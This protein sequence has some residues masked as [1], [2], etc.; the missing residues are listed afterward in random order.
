[1]ADIAKLMAIIMILL[2]GVRRLNLG[3]LLF[4]GGTLLGLLER[5]PLKKMLLALG[6]GALGVNTL[7]LLAI[8]T[9]I[10]VL[11]YLMRKHHIFE[12]MLK[13]LMQ[14]LKD[15]RTVTA[16][17]PLLIGILPSAGGAIFSAPLVE[18]V[19]KKMTLDPER[20]SFINYWFRHPWEF[21]SPLYPGIIFA[22]EILDF[23]LG[24][25]VTY[26]L[27]LGLAAVLVGILFAYRGIGPGAADKAERIDGTVAGNIALGV[28]PFFLILLAI[29]LFKI[30]L[31]LA[32]AITVGVLSLCLG[33]SPINWPGL[34]Y[35]AIVPRTLF[36]VIGLM[37]F[38]EM[39]EAT[40]IALRLP[41]VLSETGVSPLIVIGLVPFVVGFIS[42]GLSGTIAMAMPVVKG[43]VC[44]S[45]PMEIWA[46]SC[47][48]AGNM[49][50][51]THLCLSL[52][53]EYFKADISKVI[54]LLVLPIAL[55]LVLIAGWCAVVLKMAM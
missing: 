22:S 23:P 43:F 8:L 52:T 41:A 48:I 39:L 17:M 35:R 55:L 11:E 25:L 42:G 54:R 49:L 14:I 30:P 44:G 36:I 6:Q 33:Y 12:R 40:G 53:V 2:L 7:N 46:F 26:H 27:P 28:L 15:C 1:M 20:K 37:V 47:C 19:A 10:M 38:K 24:T 3:I 13:S 31:L 45:L 4:I 5:M 32:L 9:L 29:F 50:S 51:P 34:L 18:E 16:I 21:F